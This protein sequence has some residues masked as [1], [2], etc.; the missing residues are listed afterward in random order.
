MITAFFSQAAF[1]LDSSFFS[2]AE[3]ATKHMS[4]PVITFGYIIQLI[5]SLAIVIG[6]IYVASRYILPKFTPST[7]GKYITVLDRVVLE[8]Q[9]VSYILR[10]N[11]KSWLVVVTNKSATVVDKLEIKD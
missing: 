1:A 4:S 7:K 5:F 9:V 10:V 11:D 6:F 3:T 2:T 8:P